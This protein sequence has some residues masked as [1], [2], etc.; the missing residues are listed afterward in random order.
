M[1]A[2]GH[3]L[4]SFIQGRVWVGAQDGQFFCSAQLAVDCA[5]AVRFGFA[6]DGVSSRIFIH[7]NGY[8]QYHFQAVMNVSVRPCVEVKL[9]NNFAFIIVNVNAWQLEK[10]LNDREV[11]KIYCCKK[12]FIQ[13]LFSI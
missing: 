7:I 9:S 6:N 11:G 12:T 4:R 1:P 3:E 10:K 13:L 2:F 5:A 8:A